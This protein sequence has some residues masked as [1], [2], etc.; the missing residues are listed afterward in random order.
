MRT[1]RSTLSFLSMNSNYAF[2]R[3]LTS[4]KILEELFAE[5]VAFGETAWSQKLLGQNVNKQT[6]RTKDVKLVKSW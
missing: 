2:H 4:S 6:P 5:P 1:R 3:P